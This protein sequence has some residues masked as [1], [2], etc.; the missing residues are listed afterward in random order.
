M[1]HDK[2]KEI[3]V[4]EALRE[5]AKFLEETSGWE[6]KVSVSIKTYLNTWDDYAP[7]TEQF[8]RLLVDLR[9]Y[10]CR[11]DK[12]YSDRGFFSLYAHFGAKVTWEAWSSR[13]AVCERKVL[14]TEIV[15]EEVVIE[16]ET[17]E[18]E[19]EIVEWVCHPLLKA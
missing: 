13:E 14:G 4:P 12:E 15:T 19:K 5:L 3:P 7:V 6:D 10:K 1:D 17:R 9:G 18:V 16:T 2:V 11:I 8:K